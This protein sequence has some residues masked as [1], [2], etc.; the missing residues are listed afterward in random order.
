MHAVPQPFAH[1]M[2]PLAN[3]DELARQNF[4]VTLKLFMT[5]QVYP[6]DEFVYER[7]ANSSTPAPAEVL[8]RLRQVDLVVTGSA[9]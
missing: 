1:P 8:A 6:T 4:T 2:M 5:E 9:D 3:P 7:K